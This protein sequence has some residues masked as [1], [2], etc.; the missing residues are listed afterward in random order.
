MFTLIM[1]IF[2]LASVCRTSTKTQFPLEAMQSQLK[3]IL[4]SGAYTVQVLSATDV[5]H[6]AYDQLQKL[7]K[8]KDEN[9]RV[10][11]DQD[12]QRPYTAAW[13]PKP[14]RVLR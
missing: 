14:K 12:S 6:P 10:D 4:P 8:I 13:E 1:L 11:A 9:S 2:Y 5:G 3:T 7:N